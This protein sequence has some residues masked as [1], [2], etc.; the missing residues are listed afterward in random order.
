MKA[1]LCNCLGSFRIMLRTL[2]VTVVPFFIGQMKPGGTLLVKIIV[3][4]LHVLSYTLFI[5]P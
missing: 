3:V 5:G 2:Y 4:T 1:H